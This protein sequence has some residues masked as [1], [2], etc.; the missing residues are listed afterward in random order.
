MEHGCISKTKHEGTAEKIKQR[1]QYKWK[2]KDERHHEDEKLT[3]MLLNSSGSFVAVSS[4]V[5][6]SW[7]NKKF[8]CFLFSYI[9]YELQLQGLQP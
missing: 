2:R 7:S 6:P 1:K 3:C 8:S 4:A 9:E 5:K